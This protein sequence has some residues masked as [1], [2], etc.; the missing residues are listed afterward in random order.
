MTERVRDTGDELVLYDDQHTLLRVSGPTRLLGAA[1][2]GVHIRTGGTLIVSGIISRLLVIESRGACFASGYIRAVPKIADGGL[3]DVTGHLDPVCWPEADIEGTI[4][5]AAG[6]RYGQF[7]VT[8]DGSLAPYDAKGSTRV[9]D[10]TARFRML[11]CSAAG[12]Y[13]QSTQ[14]PL[15]QGQGLR[16]SIR[17]S[18]G[19]T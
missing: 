3:L 12:Q 6:A 4:L 2:G 16:R 18:E 1:H 5:I 13:G 11:T 14:L 8:A 9:N 19:S 15:T 17:A 10:G 7:V